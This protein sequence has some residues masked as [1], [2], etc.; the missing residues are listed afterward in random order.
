MVAVCVIWGLSPLYFRA[1]SHVPTLEVLC[2]RAV[3]SFVLFFG[4]LGLQGRLGLVRAALTRPGER[5]AIAAAS[6]AISGNW[7]LFILATAV[8][9]VTESSLGYY[10]FPLVSVALGRVVLGERLSAGQ[11]AAVALAAAAVGL[12][13]W[14]LGSMPLIALGLAV[15]MS[16]YGLMKRFVAAGPMVSV[17][18]EIAWVAP[19]ALAWL[20]WR[21]GA[22]HD[23]ATWALLI[24]SGPL[25]AIPLMIFAYAAK[26]ITMGTQGFVMYLNPTLQAVVAVA[27]LSE[28]FTGWHVVAFP[29]IWLALAIYSAE[30]VRAERRARRSATSAA[31]PATTVM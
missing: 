24:G 26:R 25:T 27:V 20:I 11:W 1:L 15:A 14:G 10:I 2:H 8:D 12:I 22:D 17:S 3:W 6:L 21:G 19:L 30:A 13:G 28:P 7:Y 9:R 23:A 4:I 16:F 18:A 5:L 29:L 31:G